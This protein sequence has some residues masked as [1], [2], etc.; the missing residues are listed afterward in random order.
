LLRDA[1]AERIEAV[2][3]GGAI[4]W[5]TYYFRDRRLAE[6]LLCAHRRGVNVRVTLDRQPRT[7]TANDAVIEILSGD[8]GL[9]RGLRAVQHRGIHTGRGSVWKPNL[10]TKLFCF[11]HPHPV[12]LL[13]SFNPVCDD[14]EEAPEIARALGDHDRGHNVMVEL[15]DRG[16]VAGLVAHARRL[17]SARHGFFERLPAE[18]NR[19]L[20]GAD[21]EVYFWPRARANPIVELL[22]RLGAD[23]RIRL[24]ASHLKGR[25]SLRPLLALQRRGAQLEIVASASTRRV[26][27]K[28]DRVLA[29]AGIRFQRVSETGG[30]PMHLKFMLVEG[31][32]WRR[33]VFGS[34]N[35]T[36]RSRRLNHEIAAISSDPALWTAFDERWSE[37]FAR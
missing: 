15:S 32:E 36:F 33:V 18:Q 21:T 1:L 23:A 12:A 34:Y 9:G 31:G 2:P 4:D 3:A 10:H 17:H 26:P 30:V 7:M 24:A 16:L 8:S 28:I 22:R 13:G 6:Q 11:S 14:P 27:V 5:V 20:R 25:G 29:D 35:W 37:L 19:V